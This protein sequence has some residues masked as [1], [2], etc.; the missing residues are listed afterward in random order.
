MFN[1]WDLK[2]S[3][4]TLNEV[5]NGGSVGRWFVVRDLGAALGE[6]GRFNS[7]SRCLNRARRN[8]IDTFERHPFIEG[9]EQGFVKFDYQGRQPELVRHRIAVDDVG[10]PRICSADSV[11]RSGGMPS[12][13]RRAGARRSIHPQDQGERRRRAAGDHLLESNVIEPSVSSRDAP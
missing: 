1:S 3:N 10:G 6:T 2:D 12:G 5:R 11:K 7:L 8:D 4:N 9:V 13:R